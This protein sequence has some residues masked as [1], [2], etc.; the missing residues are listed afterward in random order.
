M[1]SSPPTT[2]GDGPAVA[3]ALRAD[4]RR[5]LE[6][7]LAA[8]R[9]VF[10]EEGIDGSVEEIARR[11]GVGVGTVYRRFPHKDDLVDAIIAEHLALL[12]QVMREQLAVA[13]PWQGFAGLVHRTLELFAA[14]RGFKSVVSARWP[15]GPLP[16]VV[17]ELAALGEQ[18][19]QRAQDA[20][21]LRADFDQTDLPSIYRAVGAVM[22]ETRDVDPRQW[23][24]HLGMLLDGLRAVAATPLPVPPLSV[25]QRMA[26]RPD[27]DRRC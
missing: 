9:E 26:L 4:A 16:P 6:R 24:R 2:P 5:N 27:V 21:A 23:E 10:L 7:V 14:N 20:G 22:E 17:Q 3:P 12:D 1:A 15:D 11:A 19:V 13:D 25:E 18:I 8:A